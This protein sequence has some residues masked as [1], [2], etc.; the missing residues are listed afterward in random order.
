MPVQHYVNSNYFLLET[1]KSAYAFQISKEG[2]PVHL[3]WGAKLPR[4]EDYPT[5]PPQKQHSSFNATLHDLL[6]EYPA[7]F[8]IQ[9]LEPCLQVAFPNGVRDIRL[10]YTS[11]RLEN[12]MLEITLQDQKYGFAVTLFY[13][14]FPECDV[15]TR[16]AVIQNTGEEPVK[17][18][19]VL[20]GSVPL[21]P[22]RG[23]LRL[24]HLAGA[25]AS[26]TLLERTL[27]TPGQKVL[28]GR[29][30]YAGHANNP[31]F[32]IDTL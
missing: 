15:L 11:H 30:N 7:R 10:I 3:Y 13:R 1:S 27:I 31:F 25:W 21:P 20:S 12:E 32:A 24:T 5:L 6:D 19:E 22:D 17:L 16:R 4:W 9:E 14:V 28:E 23:D 26:E 18:E 2:K 8:G 29:L